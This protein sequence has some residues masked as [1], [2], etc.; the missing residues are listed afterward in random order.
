MLAGQLRKTM[1]LK[2]NLTAPSP[3]N[4]QVECGTTHAGCSAHIST[5]HEE[6]FNLIS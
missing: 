6:P 1:S 5:A 4:S 2:E 3:Y